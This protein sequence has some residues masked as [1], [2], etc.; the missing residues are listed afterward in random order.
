MTNKNDSTPNMYIFYSEVYEN[1]RIKLD[2][3]SFW[4]VWILYCLEVFYFYE[5]KDKKSSMYN[6]IF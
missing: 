2:L 3:S 5:L 4:L 6:Y 1:V